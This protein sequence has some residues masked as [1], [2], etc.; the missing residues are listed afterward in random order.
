M[1]NVERYHQAPHK[2]PCDCLDCAKLR[3]VQEDAYGKGHQDGYYRGVEAVKSARAWDGYIDSQSGAFRSEEV[4][5]IR[6]GGW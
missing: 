4:E 6:N 5:R 3:R 1:Q 2:I